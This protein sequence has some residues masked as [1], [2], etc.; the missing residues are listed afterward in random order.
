[1]LN[2]SAMGRRRKLVRVASTWPIGLG[3]SAAS[4]NTGA[5]ASSPWGDQK[6]LVVNGVNTG[7]R[8]SASVRALMLG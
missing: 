6:A 1:M 8:S 3:H 2:R 5:V 7:P 4:P